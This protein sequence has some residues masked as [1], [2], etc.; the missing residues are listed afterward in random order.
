MKFQILQGD[1]RNILGT[2]PD[3]HFHCCVTSPPYFGLRDYGVDGQIGLEPTPDDF[4]AAMVEVFRGA[5]RVLRDDGVCWLNL[6]DSY[7]GY[8]A[9]Q[10]GTGLE[11]KRQQYRKYIEPGAGLRFGNLK[12]KDMLGIPWRVAF[13]LQADG[14]YL[15]DAV[16]WHKPSP[17]PGSQRDR[18]TS[19]YEFVFQ[20]TKS[21]RYFFDL[22]AVKE[23]FK[24]AS[25]TR[26]SQDIDNQA[27]SQRANGGEKTNGTMKAVAFGGSKGGGEHGNAARTYSGNEWQPGSGATPRNV[28]RIA[29]EGFKDAHFA[30]YPVELAAKCIKASTSAFGCCSQCGAPWQRQ[31]EREQLKRERPNELTKRTGESG[32]GN[33][34]ANTVAGVSI[35]TL[36]WEPTCDCPDNPE[37]APCRVLDPFNGAATTGIACRRLG[38]AYTGIELNQDYIDISHKRLRAE[39]NRGHKQGTKPAANQK[40]LFR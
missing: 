13:A 5:W 36:G 21:R 39:A 15:R 16:I 34:C 1:C 38:L 19:S 30:T 24:P 23:P 17:M 28:W 32:T 33:H 9:N 14:W 3:Q 27:G 6:G 29:S 31:I 7:N 26:L 37:I 8:M 22:E 11:T 25:Y 40:E 18:C 20:L 10:R 4:V 12:P 2:L 35:E